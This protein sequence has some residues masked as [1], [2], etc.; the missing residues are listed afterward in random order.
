MMCKDNI[1][2]WSIYFSSDDLLN[3]AIFT[4]SM[5]NFIDDKNFDEKNK[6][7]PTNIVTQDFNNYDFNKLKLQWNSWFNDIIKH[8]YT[9][10]NSDKMCSSIEW[11]YDI[12]KFSELGYIELRDFCIKAYPHFNEWWNMQVGG[13]NALSFHEFVGNEN[14]SKYINEYISELEC[15]V[16]RKCRPFKLY[17]DI[18]YTG[19]PTV[20]DI[21]DEYIVV[22]PNWYFDLNKDW[23]IN[24]LSNLI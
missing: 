8:K 11:T 9:N 21:N 2:S 12:N 10:V 18:V 16:N 4:G 13:K 17:I 23:W 19:I 14:F 6:P 20:L 15:K 24:K 7:W 5:Y 22:T 1:D 3:F